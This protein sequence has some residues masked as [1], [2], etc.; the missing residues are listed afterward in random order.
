M[1]NQNKLFLLFSAIVVLLGVGYVIY[2]LL[3]KIDSSKDMYIEKSKEIVLLEKKQGQIEELKEELKKT[4]QN[5]KEIMTSILS[6]TD[7]LDFIVKIEKT[8]KLAGLSYEVRITREITQSAIDEELLALRRS[9]RRGRESEETTKEEKL[10]GVVF[11]I[12]I[13]GSYS[14]VIRFLEGVASLPYYTH[15]E[16]FNIS[17]DRKTGGEESSQV[18]SSIQ[19]TV[20]TKL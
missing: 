3:G 2:F 11:N 12:E 9:R 13:S 20:F 19:M 16:S 17:K 1:N 15:I 7:V 10:P 8:A 18:E 14:G 5:R 6:R 4:A